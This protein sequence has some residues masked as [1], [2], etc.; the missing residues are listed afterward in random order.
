MQHV[1]TQL[2]KIAIIV[3]DCSIFTL[4]S[5]R[6]ERL[7]HAHVMLVSSIATGESKILLLLTGEREEVTRPNA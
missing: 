5:R 3:V 6:D 1:N 7:P 4:L 2:V